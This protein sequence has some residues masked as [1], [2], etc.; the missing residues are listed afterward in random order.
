MKVITW[1]VR[2]INKLYKHRELKVFIK[3]NKVG[4]IAIAEHRVKEIRAAKLIKKLVPGWSWCNN[5]NSCPKGRIWILWNPNLVDF[6]KLH[7]HGQL[8]HGEVYIHSIGLRFLFTAVYGLHTIQ[9]RRGMWNE[10]KGLNQNITQAWI[11]M[12][13][14]NSVLDPD[15]RIHGNQIQDNE[16]Q[17][18]KEFLCDTHMVELKYFG[19]EFT[20]T[21]SHIH[22]KIDRAL[23]NAAWM[24]TMKQLEVMVMDPL[25]S[26]HTPLG[27]QFNNCTDG[28]PKPFR[29]FNY[30]ADLPEF[31]VTVQ[32][33]WAKPMASTGMQKVWQKLKMMKAELKKLATTNSYKV[34]AKVKEVRVM[35]QDTQEQMRSVTRDTSLCDIEKDLKIQLEKWSNVEESIFMQ[36][37]RCSGLKWGIPILHT[38]MRV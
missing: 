7:K 10:L 2:D 30:V 15:D 19:R 29:F 6:R 8:I 11:A 4:V 25:F 32:K 13:D 33:I 35:L 36:K 18:F 16:V 5:Y 31:Q 12:G 28:G 22:S 3:E 24:N 37:S 38:S 9:D 34:S 1:N 17:D 14:Y 26:D 20:W 21:N 23:V 27:I